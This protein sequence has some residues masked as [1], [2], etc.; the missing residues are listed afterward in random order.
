MNP[1]PLASVVE[2]R[3]QIEHRE[4]HRSENL[5]DSALHQK[6]VPYP[7]SSTSSLVTSPPTSSVGRESNKSPVGN[8]A[9]ANVQFGAK[10]LAYKSKRVFKVCIKK[11]AST[12]MFC[13]F[14][15]L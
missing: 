3:P 9:N 2:Y 13:I 10:K 4:P 6:F 14:R 5:G 1:N 8:V 11:S 12:A 15:S 7:T